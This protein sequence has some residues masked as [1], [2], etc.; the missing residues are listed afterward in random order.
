MSNSWQQTTP[1][2]TTIEA[3]GLR[4]GIQTGAEVTY[5]KS[6]DLTR[7]IQGSEIFPSGEASGAIVALLGIDGMVNAHEIS[8][9][10]PPGQTDLETIEQTIGLL[11]EVRDA[12]RKMTMTA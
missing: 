8:L 7:A 6:D 12:L 9:E 11:T 10:A 4:L 2:G 1:V 3:F 5:S